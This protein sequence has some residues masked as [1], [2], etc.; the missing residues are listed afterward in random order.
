MGTSINKRKNGFNFSV[1][2]L[3]GILCALTMRSLSSSRTHLVPINDEPFF[4]EIAR[5]F[6]ARGNTI[7]VAKAYF[8]GEI[9]EDI[10]HPLH[11]ILMSFL[12]DQS[13]K[14]FTRSKLLSLFLALLLTLCV[15]LFS[16]KIWGPQIGIAAA[17]MVGLSPITSALSQEILSDILFTIF[18]FY[19]LTQLIHKPSSRHW[20]LFGIA[21]GLGYLT[22]GNSHFLFVSALVVGLYI[23]KLNFFLKPYFYLAVASFCISASFL[24]VR[25]IIVWGAPL[26]NRNNKIFWVNSRETYLQ[27]FHTP[28][29]DNIGFGW[30]FSHHSFSEAFFHFWNGFKASLAM[31]AF[32]ASQGPKKNPIFLVCSGLIIFGCAIIGGRERWKSGEK[33]E[34]LALVSSNLVLFLL[35]SWYLQGQEAHWRY[36]FPIAISFFPWAILGAIKIAEPVL[37]RVK[38]TNQSPFR[39]I[40]WMIG[41]FSLLIVLNNA[42]ALKHNPINFWAV[43]AFWS[44]ISSWICE[45]RPSSKILVDNRSRYSPWERCRVSREQYP[46]W[47]PKKTLSDF[48]ERQNISVTLLEGSLIEK[49][50]YQEKYG[51]W[52]KKGPISFLDWPRCFSDNNEPSFL[53]IYSMDCSE[54]TSQFTQ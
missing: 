50:P 41:I 38:K 34:V 51:P 23:Y 20:I 19:A 3:F 33:Q 40:N 37:T 47:I 28:E 25:N 44:D 13:P 24:L 53:L 5:D 36:T 11:P 46:F 4:I 42:S 32:S 15:F 10:R 14:D 7:D 45:N 8:K 35:F 22:K 43:P 18:Y 2:L 31:L 52:D 48:A 54:H 21:A 26:H 39:A 27:L 16:S 30:Y 9:N 29:W 6:S 49:D 1:I 17:A 12:I